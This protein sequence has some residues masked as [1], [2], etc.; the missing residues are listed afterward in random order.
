MSRASA[1]PLDLPIVIG[2]ALAAIVAATMTL[3][4]AKSFTSKYYGVPVPPY[5]LLETIRRFTAK[6]S[7]EW[8][9]AVTRASGAVCRVRLP[10]PAPVYVVADA[11]VARALLTSPSSYKRAAIYSVARGL[12]GFTDTIFTHLD[13]HSGSLWA[14]KRKGVVPA[15]Q[16]KCVA[17]VSAQCAGPISPP[18][19]RR[20]SSPS[21][22]RTGTWTCAPS[23]SA[24]RSE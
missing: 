19:Q 24:L 13:I 11:E 18:G 15:F 22:S 9:L 12:T 21:P 23:S 3:L 8:L 17:R 10:L 20:S 2:A 16:P 1:L 7:A 14:T 5:G 4:C 6:S